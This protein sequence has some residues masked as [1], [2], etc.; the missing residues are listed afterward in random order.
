[1]LIKKI[2]KV[3]QMLLQNH[4]D[5]Y[6]FPSLTA[7]FHTTEKVKCGVHLLSWTPR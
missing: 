2:T 5:T 6:G 1:M 3:V 7:H 4:V